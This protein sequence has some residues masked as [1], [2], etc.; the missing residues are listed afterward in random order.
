[1]HYG[2]DL[3][4]QY[5]APALKIITSIYWKRIS[6]QTLQKMFYHDGYASFV[7]GIVG[8]INELYAGVEASVELNLLPNITLGLAFTFQKSNYEKDPS[9]QL[10]YVNDLHLLESGLLHLKQA[11]SSSSPGLVNAFS[12]KY[13]PYSTLQLNIALLMAQNRPVSIDLFR[14]SDFVQHKIDAISWGMISATHYLK[15]N[16]FLNAS[17]FKSFQINKGG[18]SNKCRVGFVV[19]N[20]L[21]HFLPL[22]AYEQA[23]FDYVHF[24][25]NKYAPKYLID[26][27]VAYTIHFQITIQ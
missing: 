16:S 10:L 18:R 21:N 3:G 7:D 19:N 17:I 20:V 13:Q 5:H 6:N 11:A 27:G 26:Q 2:V 22:I 25:I 1:M 23:R 9:F 4:V 24:D 8:N 12:I 14:R 15:D